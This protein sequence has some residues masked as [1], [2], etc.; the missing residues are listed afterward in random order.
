MWMVLGRVLRMSMPHL[1]PLAV[2][3]LLVAVAVAVAVL[4]TV[5]NQHSLSY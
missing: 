5:N 4:A 2:L 1:G 3:L